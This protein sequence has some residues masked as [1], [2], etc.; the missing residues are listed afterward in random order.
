MQPHLQHVHGIHPQLQAAHQ[1]GVKPGSSY[2]DAC[3]LLREVLSQTN[4]IS[5]PKLEDHSG[6]LKLLMSLH[7]DSPK[8]K[9]PL[10]KHNKRQN[11]V[12][13][14]SWATLNQEHGLYGL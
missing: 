3:R 1:E 8:R 14:C 9:N 5:V 13:I 12:Q 4:L 11:L 2:R 10:Q 7:L 6:K